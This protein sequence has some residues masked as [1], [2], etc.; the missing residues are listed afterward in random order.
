MYE[1]FIS[2]PFVNEIIMFCNKYPP[3]FHDERSYLFLFN[4]FHLLL[5][6][7]NKHQEGKPAQDHW[8]IQVELLASCFCRKSLQWRSCI[9][10]VLWIS[11]LIKSILLLGIYLRNRRTRKPRKTQGCR[12]WKLRS[13]PSLGK[14][15]F[16]GQGPVFCYE[17]WK[18][19]KRNKFSR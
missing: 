18:V 17:N 7:K 15:L 5:L 12:L 11:R 2:H 4:T 8:E 9:V 19:T 10:R 6:P 16:R 3:G 1:N 13:L 14:S